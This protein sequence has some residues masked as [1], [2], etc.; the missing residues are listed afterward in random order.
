MGSRAL[1]ALLAV[2]AAIAFAGALASGVL[3]G[4]IVP[5]WWDG[6][7]QIGDKVIERKDIHVGLLGASGCNLGETVECQPLDVGSELEILGYVELGLGGL[8]MLFA[9]AL[10]VSAWR[11]GDGRKTVAKLA[12]IVAALAS[13]GVALL[14]IRGPDL[15]A[16]Q[17]VNVPI[18]FGL[19]LFWSG[20]GATAI[21]AIAT[22]RVRKEPLRLKP[23]LPHVDVPSPQPVDVRDLLVQQHDTLRPAALGPEPRIGAP[24]PPSPPPGPVVERAP[25]LRPL[26]DMHGVIPAPAPPAMPTRAPTP[27]PRAS[28]EAI[29]G[30]PQPPPRPT[31]A[32]PPHHPPPQPPPPPGVAHAMAPEPGTIAAHPAPPPRPTP[33]PPAIPPARPTPP[34]TAP[35]PI[36]GRQAAP[37]PPHDHERAESGPIDPPPPVAP[38]APV[39]LVPTAPLVMPVAIPALRAAALTTPKRS[40]AS[41]LPAPKAAPGRSSKPSISLPAIGKKTPPGGDRAMPEKRS[42]I[43]IA[44]PPPPKSD[45]ERSKVVP[46]REDTESDG[47]L[48]AAMRETDYVTAVEIDAEAKAAANAAAAD[49]RR[50]DGEAP[51]VPARPPVDD[52]QE[53]AARERVSASE[54]NVKPAVA[55]AVVAYAPVLPAPEP[56]PTPEPAAP[57]KLPISTAPASLPPP[58]NAQVATSG[59]T[60]ACPQCEAPMAWVEEHLR[61]YCKQCRMYF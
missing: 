19:I 39:P 26:Y 18:G 43:A 12:L 32:P 40:S 2:T 1:G 14:M 28:V 50:H 31:P 52:D 51:T 58:K 55:Q 17:P 36:A 56:A 44:V 59:P 22:M 60:P 20:A 37:P 45:T 33:P 11:I 61:F 21:A 57:A 5:G 41:Q 16:G 13:I 48:E 10:A 35:P 29:V 34:P 24:Q 30:L 38:V 42:T 4:A 15:E 7:P 3:A 46:A 6:H 47:K 54:I 8:A 49:R 9:I 25:Q 53:T 23:S 27:M